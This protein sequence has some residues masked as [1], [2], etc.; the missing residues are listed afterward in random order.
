VE[1]PEIQAVRSK[2]RD[3]LPGYVFQPQPLKGIAVLILIPIFATLTWF[4]IYFSPKWYFCVILAIAIG[5]IYTIWGFAAHEALH[6]AIFH[7]TFGR[8]LLG[9]LGYVP[10]L[11]SPLTWVFWHC[12]CHHGNTNCV[13]KDP[14]FIGTIDSFSNSRITRLRAMFTPGTHHWFSYIGFLCLFTLEGQYVL[15]FHEVGTDIERKF[16]F[17]RNRAKIETIIMF[18][19][20]LLFGIAIGLKA[21]L[22]IIIFPM[23]FANYVYVSYILTQHL[24]RAPSE[25]VVNPLKSTISVIVPPMWD[26]LHLHFGY[27]VEHHLFPNMSHQFGPQVRQ[28]LQ[29]S[30]QDEYVSVPYFKALEYILK[31]PRVHYDYET[32]VE[33]T[34]RLMF[35]IESS[36]TQMIHESKT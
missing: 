31:T 22:T 17:K 19:S 12:Q 3:S 5:Q 1:S 27:H 2:I 14:D 36:L 30:Y 21:S 4:T 28:I 15:W 33:P 32:L 35:N 18:F 6:G 26:F 20:W 13:D 24:L 11:I 16:S 34:S 8:Y 9:Y 25:N 23:L 29:V 10:F 7:S